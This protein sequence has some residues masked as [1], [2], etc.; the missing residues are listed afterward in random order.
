MRIVLA[1]ML[2]Q[3]LSS[4]GEPGDRPQKVVTEYT[5]YEEC[6]DREAA[7]IGPMG[8]LSKDQAYQVSKQCAA[9]LPGRDAGID[10]EAECQNLGQMSREFPSC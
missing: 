9:L 1:I 3:P 10:G 8:S 4:C 7:K 6:I 2:A 5:Q